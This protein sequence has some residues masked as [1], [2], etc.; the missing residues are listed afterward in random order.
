M[1]NKNE[2]KVTIV[3]NA[4]QYEV[5]KDKIT[6]AEVVTLAFPDYPQNPQNTYSV[7]YK[8]G[9]SDKPEGTLSPGGSVQVHEGMVFNV[10]LTG[11]S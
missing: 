8:R 4:T 10:S 6:Y 5:D 11:Q 2:K 1:A 7:K 3:V 9:H